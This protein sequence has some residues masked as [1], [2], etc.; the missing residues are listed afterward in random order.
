MNTPMIQR[1]TS[2]S[3][4][5]VAFCRFLRQKGF[6][7]GPGEEADAL[8]AM[9]TLGP[10][11]T[12]DQLQLCLRSALARTYAQLR[13]FDELYTQYWREL[14]KA[15]DSKV[16]HA[17]DKKEQKSRKSGTP[18]L[19]SIKSWL[20][21][22][23]TTEEAEMATYST[24]E[25]LSR[26]DFSLLAEEE[27]SEMSAMIHRIARTLALRESRRRK[28]SNKP[29]Q[30]DLRRTL[31]QNMRRGGE[32]LELAHFKPA[33]HKKQIVLLCDVSKSMDLYSRFLLQF[34]YAFQSNYRRI[35]AFAFSTQLYRVTPA[36]RQRDFKSALEEVAVQVSGWSGGTKIGASLHRFYSRYGSR[37]LNRQTVVII[38]SD[39]WDTGDTEQLESSMR[40]IH[41]KAA[42]V[43]WLNPLA[44]STRYEPKTQGMQA[45][46]P[47]IDIF[48]PGHSVESLRQLYHQL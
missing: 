3:A 6:T 44:G 26:K 34:V 43:I 29:L 8:R 11:D 7:I 9:S 27:L 12:P 18:G 36:L 35:E 19:Q 13:I 15:V 16:K 45:A 10:F 33:R 41:R 22:N 47:F 20:Q 23:T 25:V 1:Q 28:A 24:Q 30:L 48:A 46:M 5:V 40:R 4:N 21:G 32:L 39:G 37:L 14:E 38:M 31:R 17:R 2:L 42:K